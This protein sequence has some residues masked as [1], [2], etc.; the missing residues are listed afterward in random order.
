MAQFLDTV[1][2][3][4]NQNQIAIQHLQSKIND[5]EFSIKEEA[6][7]KAALQSPKYQSELSL[8]KM[9]ITLERMIS[10]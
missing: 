4:R 3:K 9:N 2:E 7:T 6:K 10:K 1:I 8:L 5:I